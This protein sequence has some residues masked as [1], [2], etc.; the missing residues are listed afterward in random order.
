MVIISISHFKQ[1]HTPTNFLLLS[2]AVADLLVGLI[3]MPFVMI[4]Y[5]ETCWYFG[6]MFCIIF[7]S[8][9]CILTVVSL[10][11]VIFISIDRYFAVCD[12]LQYSNKITV[13]FTCFCIIL[14]WTFSVLY[15]VVVVNFNINFK[16]TEGLNACLGEC[17]FEISAPW[18]I[19]DMLVSFILPCSVMIA[20]YIKIFIVA[21]RHARVI[22]TVTEQL[23]CKKRSNSKIPKRSERKAAKTLISVVAAFLLCW[24]PYYIGSIVE[25]SLSVSS[26]AQVINALIFLANFNSAMNPVIYALFYPWFQKSIKEILTFRICYPSSTLI[27]LFTEHH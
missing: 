9:L 18:V 2:L 27:N 1:L 24:M 3:V 6:R 12:P 19:V 21:K 10:S 23:K 8:V 22:K 20:L 17:L 15:V 14:S 4:R 25:G 7:Y 26:S 5:I 16:S 13:N 11:N